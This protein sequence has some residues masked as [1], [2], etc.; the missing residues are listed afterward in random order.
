[1]L[2]GYTSLWAACASSGVLVPVPE[3]LPLILAG[4]LVA[5]GQWS[6]FPAV[7]VAVFGVLTR[8]IL[9]WGVGR[10]LG[11]L[12]LDD[13]RASRWL[14]RPTV[15]RAQRLVTRHGA[16]A[17]LIGRF[18]IGF[19][20]P[21]FAVA[22]AMGVSFREF[23]WWDFLGLWVAVPVAMGLGYWFGHP[24]HGAATTITEVGRTW[25]I[26]LSFAILG[27]VIWRWGAIRRATPEEAR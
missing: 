2:S 22:G 10:V 19:R 8:D 12:I 27:L 14:H 15:E 6:W 18:M 16:A 24:L 11:S 20:V 7:L 25:A 23:V 17:V 1:V 21:F 9:A 5:D 13:E 4:I 3:D 26:P